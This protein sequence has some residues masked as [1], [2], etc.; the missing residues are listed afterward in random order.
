MSRSRTLNLAVFAFALPLALVASCTYGPSRIEP[1]SISPGGSADQAMEMYDA[2]DDGYL[3][4]AELDQ[5]PGLKA[6][7]ETLDTDKDGK[8]SEDEI[9][10]RIET[11]QSTRLGLLPITL[12]VTINGVPLQNATVTFE[13][14]PFLGDEIKPASSKT[15]EFGGGAPTVPK[16][17]RPDPQRTPA[18]IALGLYRVKISKV[19]NNKE[20]I[21]RKYNEDTVIGQEVAPDVPALA[22][23]RLTYDLSKN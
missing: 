6:A 10:E 5:V 11:W 7:I 13:P 23:L 22:T 3:A 2:D 18:G 14:E 12:T 19:V 1:P 9:A 17:L 21:P 8:V 20:T 16:E 4:G 15:D